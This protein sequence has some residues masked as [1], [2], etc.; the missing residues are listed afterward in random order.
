MSRRYSGSARR[1]RRGPV[2]QNQTGLFIF[3]GTSAVLS[4]IVLLVFTNNPAIPV[5]ETE[6]IVAAFDPPGNG[7]SGVNFVVIG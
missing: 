3:L 7:I 5:D 2:R 6:A 1:Y 4:F